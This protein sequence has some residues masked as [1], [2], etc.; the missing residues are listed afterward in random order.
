MS[1]PVPNW[2]ICSPRVQCAGPAEVPG[3][4]RPLWQ[5]KTTS[6][7]RSRAGAAGTL[8]EYASAGT[9]DGHPAGLP[10]GVL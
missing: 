10:V 5:A 1:D 8:R 3:M 2:V 7:A 9:R 6:W 4:A